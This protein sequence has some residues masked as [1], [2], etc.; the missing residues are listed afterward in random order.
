VTWGASARTTYDPVSGA[1]KLIAYV[2][3]LEVVALTRV[4]QLVPDRRCTHT[5]REDTPGRRPVTATVSD[6]IAVDGVNRRYGAWEV[7]PHSR[8]VT[9]ASAFQDTATAR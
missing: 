9:A 4:T 3:E 6:A 2:P 7:T 1:L 8:D 5:G